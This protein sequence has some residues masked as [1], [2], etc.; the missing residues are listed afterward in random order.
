M[1]WLCLV[2]VLLGACGSKTKQ[3]CF[4]DDAYCLDYPASWSVRKD[5]NK[6]ANLQ[7]GNNF[8]EAYLIVISESKASLREDMNLQ[9]FSRITRGFLEKAHPDLHSYE[10]E[11]M[12]INGLAALRYTLKGRAGDLRL[13]YWHYSLEDETH[14]H[15]IL[16]W[17]L[18]DTFGKNQLDFERTA[19]S[20][21]RNSGNA[22][23]EK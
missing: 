3:V 2:F 13:K 22:G 7:L 20:F 23:Q 9:D 1:R 14:F 10:P 17:S 19:L 5:L 4:L 6:S 15:Q 16:I 18:Q 12:T 8:A 21:R 11:F